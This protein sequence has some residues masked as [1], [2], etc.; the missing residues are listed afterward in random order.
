MSTG[1]LRFGFGR[2][3]PIVLQAEAAECGIA[4]LAMV[5]GYHG[6]PI[7]LATFRQRH[8][9]SLKGTTL[10][11]LIQIAETV[12]LTARPLRL[13]IDAIGQLQRPCILHWG[14][15]HF[16]VLAE[17][18]ARSVVI[19]DPARG[20][21][22]VPLDEVSREFTGVA[23]ETIPT[24]DFTRRDERSGLRLRDLFRHVAGLRPALLRIA[25]LSLGVEV[26]A[27][28]LPVGSQVIID[29][30][31]VSAD[32]D[33]L[34]TITMGLG[35][36]LLL[37][38]L[39]NTARSWAIM[40]IGSTV[41]LQ[42]YSSLFDHLSR[43]S[44]EYFEK[45]NVGDILS[46]FGSLA[47]IQKT[48]T[49]GF[50]QA[51]LDGVMSIGM[52]GMLFLYG[53]WLGWIALIAT[54]LDL[55]LRLVMLRAYRESSEEAIIHDARQQTHLI[56]TIRGAASVRL[57]GLR[58]RRRA[59]WIN[60][61]VDSLNARLRLQRLDI[62]FT[63]AGELIFGLDRIVMLALGARAVMHDQMSVGMLVAFLT[64]KDQ[65]SM[66]AGSLVKGWFEL[67]MLDVQTSRLS[68]I[69]QAE[70][71]A[72]TT[73]VPAVAR[74]PRSERHV[75]DGLRGEDLALRYG[76]QDPWI[77]R[78]LSLHVQAGQSVAIVGP[79]G[80]GKTT[81]L[82]VLMGLIPPQEGSIR[83]DGADIRSLGLDA[84]RSR[85]SGVL[86]DDGLFAGSIA[87]NIAGFDE[88]PDQAWIEDCAFRAAIVDD[89]ARMPMRFETLVGDMGSS[90]SGG[91]KQRIVLARALYR[92]PE[93]LF[94]DEA[95]SHLDDAN[96]ALVASALQDLDITRIIVAHRP[97]TIARAD[98][99]LRLE[100][101]AQVPLRSIAD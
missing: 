54:F 85:I 44:L 72:R 19:H 26:A 90:L 48:L 76:A 47:A 99:V 38:L 101:T 20:R 21:R 79:S 28:L 1:P 82:K 59:A 57:L 83:L 49:T 3:L 63:R 7:D 12:G 18:G 10:R 13:D 41:S 77:W 66:R 27:L 24:R 16:V 46:R 50:V 81:L 95:T 84:Y 64:Y 14:M 17:V 88:H 69:T 8:A 80:C 43:L 53:G 11:T 56:E 31:I 22:T 62:V 9:V 51:L 70:P 55:G 36:L 91:Q 39:I 75:A 5:L 30:A 68:D 100:P 23:L 96:E 78:N 71:E 67:R 40:L 35:L 32:H 33:L 34:L 29:E 86:Q 37:Q 25:M 58:E 73:L 94:L 15:N 98:L 93:I 92:R 45:R 87:E 89:I 97:A 2:R 65:L 4:C 52:A 42:W 61:L 60:H 74:E 6:R